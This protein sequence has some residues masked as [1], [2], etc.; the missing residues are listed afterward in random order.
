MKGINKPLRRIIDIRDLFI[1]V[2]CAYPA[3]MF[4]IEDIN[5]SN[6]IYYLLVHWG[7]YQQ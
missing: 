2:Y 6:S 1:E 4:G 7:N 5:L 3:K